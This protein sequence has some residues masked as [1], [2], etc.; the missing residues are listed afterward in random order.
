MLAVEAIP[1]IASTRLWK[2]ARSFLL[3]RRLCLWQLF[4][5]LKI[6]WII[7][8]NADG[9]QNLGRQRNGGGQFDRVPLRCYF[10]RLRTRRR[11]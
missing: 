3:A 2:P 5:S 10:C 7:F 11:Q 6:G 8:N 4:H 9:N 1:V